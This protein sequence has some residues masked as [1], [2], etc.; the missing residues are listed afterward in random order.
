MRYRSLLS[1]PSQ[2]AINAN[3]FRDSLDKTS[4]SPFANSLIVGECYATKDSFIIGVACDKKLGGGGSEARKR[5]SLKSG[6]L[7]PSSLIEVYAYDNNYFCT[8]SLRAVNVEV[9]ENVISMLSHALQS[10]FPCRF[11]FSART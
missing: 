6:G 5:R 11:T 4:S 1:G 3:F 9:R 7:K 8:P 10:R 2:T